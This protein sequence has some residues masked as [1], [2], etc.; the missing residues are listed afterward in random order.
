M[1]DRNGRHKAAGHVLSG[2]AESNLMIDTSSHIQEIMQEDE[3]DKPRI[4]LFDCTEVI[5]CPGFCFEMLCTFAAGQILE[6]S[7]S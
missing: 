6:S 2:K 7:L 3:K 4:A 1:K 5:S